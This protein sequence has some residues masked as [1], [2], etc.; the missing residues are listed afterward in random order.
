MAG[1]NF[2]LLKELKELFGIKE[3]PQLVSFWFCRAE[4]VED[5][6]ADF[7]EDFELYTLYKKRSFGLTINSGAVMQRKSVVV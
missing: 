7:P 1:F 4:Y 5:K 6:T 3:H 2:D